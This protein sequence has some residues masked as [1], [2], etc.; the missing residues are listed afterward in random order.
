MVFIWRGAG[1]LIPIFIFIV[2]WIV[3][4]WYDD[5]TLGNNEFLGWTCF[6]SGIILF[7][8]GGLAALGENAEEEESQGP[9]K[10]KKKNDFFWIPGWGWG[11]ILT[12]LAVYLLWIKSEPPAHDYEASVREMREAQA[13][14]AALDEIA[15]AD[16]PRTLH[17]Y[18]DTPDSLKLI[19][20]DK[21][22]IVITTEIGGGKY[23][24]GDYGPDTYFFA[25]YT[26]EDETVVAFPTNEEFTKNEE[27]YTL[28]EADKGP[29]WH[30]IVGPATLEEDDYDDAW[31]LLSGTQ[32]L[33]TVEITPVYKGMK[34]DSVAHFNWEENVIEILDGTD[35]M[36]PL[37]HYDNHGEEFLV[38]EPDDKLPDSGS[39]K[40]HYFVLMPIPHGAEVNNDMIVEYLY[41]VW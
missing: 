27:L 24:Y 16:L 31:M 29:T 37:Y 13:Q 39:G 21:D 10:P 6:Y 32:D 3:S 8:L 7:V 28:V 41:K 30:R 1:F 14:Q 33:V 2:G 23:K 26:M 18:N 25:S 34:Y 36:E 11:G 15:E 22:G 17:F 20:A 9:P 4:F 12:A 5:T 35:L 19:L 38:F 40:D